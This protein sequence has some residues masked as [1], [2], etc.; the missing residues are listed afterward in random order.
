MERGK[1]KIRIVIDANILF[2]AL[3]KDAS[4]TRELITSDDIFDIYCPKLFLK[5]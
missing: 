1:E 2:S 5:S 4:I 3:I